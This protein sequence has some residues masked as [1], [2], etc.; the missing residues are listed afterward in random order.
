MKRLGFLLGAGLALLLAAC[1]GQMGGKP[2]SPAVAVPEGPRVTPYPDWKSGNADFECRQA[3]VTFDG[4]YK[5]DPPTSGTYPLDTYGHQVTVNFS[6]DGRYVDWSSNLAIAAVIVKGGPGANVYLYDPPATSGIGLRSPDHPT[7]GQIPAISHVAFCWEYRLSA[8]KT[9]ETRYTRQ[10]YWEIH[11]MGDRSE[12]T[13][14]AG[15]VFPVNYQVR[16]AVS[17]FE[18]RDFAVRG[19]ITLRNNTP[20]PFVVQ[21]VSDLV[22]P[23]M[24]ASVDCGPLPR[25]LEPGQSLSC[26]YQAPLPNKEART[27][28]ATAT[29]V[30]QG[31]ERLRQVS[32]TAPVTF[33]E[34]T[35][36]VDGQVEVF[37]DRYPYGPL[38]SVAA[39][40][41]P[42]TFAYTLNV[43]PYPCG[44]QD[45]SYLFTNTASLRTNTTGSTATSS[46]TVQVR[47]PACA[48]GC[49][50]TQGYWKTHTKYGPA[51]PRNSTWDRVG[52]KGE[53]TDFYRSN[54][55]YYQVLWTPPSG[56]NPYYQLAHQFIAAKLNQL[57]GAAT[58]P[59]V[60]EALTWAEGFFS[61]YTPSGPFSRT[62]T[63][64]ARTYASILAQYN[65]GYLGPGPC[66]E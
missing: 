28:T 9:A 20:I 52:P 61:A 17:R 24:P 45:T 37:D 26:T 66:S 12:L 63:H 32:A 59:A 14:S 55:T 53:D 58:P 44:N 56:G 15:Q 2:L 21:S 10:Y 40:E 1:G 62:L 16:V 36:V 46:W 38:G 11:K 8:E 3:V 42:K 35:K 51:K 29:Y 33:G 30:R 60:A 18:E 13:L 5:I 6:P 47:V 39:G 41:A 48:Q 43:G 27:N 50:L 57:N 4:A 19:T 34:P 23:D 25:T 7:S 49:T 31:Q 64:Q 22:S 65:E 54:Q